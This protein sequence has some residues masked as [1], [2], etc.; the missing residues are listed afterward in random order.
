MRLLIVGSLLALSL[1]A[2][3]LAAQEPA[4]PADSSQA[5]PPSPPPP[6]PEQQRYLQGLRTA[7][8]GVAQVKDG[9]DRVTRSQSSKDT[10]YKSRSA[11]RLAGL[12]GAARGFL[13]SGRGQ[14][15]PTAYQAPTRKPA[16]DL[17][18]QVDSLVLAVKGCQQTAAK[19]P[20]AVS[21]EL[22]GRLRAYE[23]ALA[24][25]RTAIGLPNR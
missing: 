15:E 13:V 23:A 9:V 8:R 25:F 6:T 21:V 14:M 19:Q 22:V 11:K 3:V 12:C 24:T 17:A 1:S 4:S 10:L 20:E 5:A 18:V 7:G 2:S 16:R